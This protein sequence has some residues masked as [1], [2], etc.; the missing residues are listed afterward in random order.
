MS[1]IIQ[2]ITIYW[3]KG[4]RGGLDA[5]KRNSIHESFELPINACINLADNSIIVH[6]IRCNSYDN[7][8]IRENVYAVESPEIKIKGSLVKIGKEVVQ[9][10]FK[11]S[12]YDCGKPYRSNHDEMGTLIPLEEKAFDLHDN[13]Y[14]RIVFN[15]RYTDMYN[16]SWWYE[17]KVHNIIRTTKNEKDI[18]IKNNVLK[19]YEQ[20]EILR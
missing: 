10:Y 14:G 18:F 17:K 9:V 16:S 15:G 11:Y 6:E 1:V 20:L 13:E 8:E 5:A 19:K 12:D 7:F 4:H 2:S 3:G